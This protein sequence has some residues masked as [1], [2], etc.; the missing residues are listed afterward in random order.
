MLHNII[1]CWSPIN[2]PTILLVVS[3]SSQCITRSLLC[4]SIKNSFVCT[5]RYH[6]RYRFSFFRA[7]SLLCTSLKDV[8][9]YRLPLIFKSGL[10]LAPTSSASSRSYLYD[11]YHTPWTTGW[12]KAHK[13]YYLLALQMSKKGQHAAAKPWMRRF[14]VT[15]F[16]T[17]R[18]FRH[19]R[20]GYWEPADPSLG[21]PGKCFC[22]KH[23]YYKNTVRISI[24][25]KSSPSFVRPITM[26]SLIACTCCTSFADL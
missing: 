17:W 13:F 22:I 20:E 11:F 16:S 1:A 14:S 24:T 15:H 26:I 18:T 3:F 2:L 21:L 5:G 23:H 7:D 10:S 8:A 9:I 25:T 12:H 6:H 19:G 4:N